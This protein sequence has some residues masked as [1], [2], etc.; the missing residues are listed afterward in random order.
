MSHVKDNP[1]GHNYGTDSVT[2]SEESLYFFVIGAAV[3]C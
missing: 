3:S 1:D 2:D